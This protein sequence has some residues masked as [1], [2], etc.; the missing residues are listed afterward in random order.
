ME[1]GTPAEKIP[2]RLSLPLHL[3][4]KIF[5]LIISRYNNNSYGLEGK[6]TL[7]GISRMIG[8]TSL[9]FLRSSLNYSLGSQLQ[10]KPPTF[11]GGF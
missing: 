4:S 3:R 9:E 10:K 5:R 2:E 6:G 7:S 8:L 1:A 11:G